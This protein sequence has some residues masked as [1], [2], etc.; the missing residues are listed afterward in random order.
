MNPAPPVT[1]QSK[2]RVSLPETSRARA[3]RARHGPDTR[4]TLVGLGAVRD[5]RERGR[6]SRARSISLSRPTAYRRRV[7]E[8]E[9]I[10]AET[11]TIRIHRDP[12]AQPFDS[13]DVGGPWCPPF[14]RRRRPR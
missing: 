5:P 1:R 4:T 3:A 10:G 2:A 6:C 7:P 13:P 8:R 9:E 12:T 11:G 14:E